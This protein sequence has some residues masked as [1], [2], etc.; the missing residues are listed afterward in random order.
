MT[1]LPPSDV[2]AQDDLFRHVNAAW[3]AETEIP[4]DK[5]TYGSFH[6]LV[7]AAEI[8]VR[9]IIEDASKAGNDVAGSPAQLIGDLYRSFMDVDAVEARGAEPARTHLAAITAVTGIEDFLLLCGRLQRVGTGALP[10]WYVDSDPDQPDRYTVRFHQS[11]LGLP[12]ESYYRGEEHAEIR[13]K[14]VAHIAR[15]LT[16]AGIDDADEIAADV[17]ALETA[18]AAT[19]WDRVRTRDVSQTHN[20]MGPEEL[21]QLW[22]QPWWNSWLAGLQAPAGMLDHVIVGEP[23]FFSGVAELLDMQRLQQ[24]KRWL[25]WKAVHAAA[26]YCSSDLVE[27]NFDFYGRTLSGTPQLR[28]RWKRGVSM[29]QGAVGEAVG[30]LYVERHFPPAAKQ[31][32]DVLVAN[33]LRA[34][35]QE[36]NQ[37]PW[38]SAQTKARALE[39]LQSFNPKIGYPVRWRNYSSLLATPDDLLGN[40]ERAEEFE[41]NRE[42]AKLG[43]PVDR[44]EW[45]MTPQTV[46]AYYNPGMN[47]I[48][49]PAAILSPPFFD[50]EA[51]DATNYGG[52]GAVIGHEIGHGFDDQ[53]SKYDGSG[54]L[55]DWW[56]DADRAAFEALTSKLIAQFSAL[57][58]AEAP[59]H[60]VNGALT[61]GENIGDLGGLG[62]AYQAWLISLGDRRPE[63]IDGLTGA[64]RLFASWAS[65]WRTKARPEEVLQRLTTD[66]HSPPEF[67][68]N[69]VVRNLDEF[70]TAYDVQPSDGLWL[71]PAQR[72]RIW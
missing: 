61:V 40:I 7:D 9:E 27:E 25:I 43:S 55:N 59:G 68:C 29:V 10:G 17:M 50:F 42:L 11:G 26:P 52:I 60:H 2:R 31:R 53:G 16:L 19:H 69:Q 65:V 1:A 8:A 3:L 51:D 66:P 56:T 64:Q 48:V 46:N 5:S 30:A 38:M 4:E 37:L 49:F 13:Q 20:P 23:S 6:E 70:Y 15:L 32:M 24:W 67:R 63:V 47:E 22:P 57:T 41:V 14:Y 18:I 58:P 21:A 44:D 39:K 28:E 12:D 62:I 71:D 72:V 34:Y 54:A 35:E 45:F 36:I 33:L